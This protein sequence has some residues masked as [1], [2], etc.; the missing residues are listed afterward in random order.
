MGGS[1]CS[2]LL[3]KEEKRAVE[4]GFFDTEWFGRF[5]CISERPVFLV[6]GAH[7]EDAAKDCGNQ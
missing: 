5:T 1:T 2:G 7:N 3:K 4:T 6:D